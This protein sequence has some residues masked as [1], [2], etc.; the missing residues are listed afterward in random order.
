MR[1]VDL[2]RQPWERVGS[3]VASVRVVAEERASRQ[4][5]VMLVTIIAWIVLGAIA[6][7]IAGFLVKGDEGMGIIGHIVLGIVG[8]VVGGFAANLLGI[9]TG[10]ANEDIVNVQSIIVAVVGAVIVVFV[11]GMFTGSRRGR[12]TV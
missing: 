6:G 10:R 7:Y 3:H 5:V 9:G 11:V 12:G 1:Q 2:A 4:E 8:A